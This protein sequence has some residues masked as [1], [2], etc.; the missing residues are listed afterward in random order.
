MM[1]QLL[2]FFDVYINVNI[3]I[4][5]YLTFGRTY[6]IVADTD[7]ARGMSWTPLKTAVLRPYREKCGERAERPLTYSR[8]V[9]VE[10][11]R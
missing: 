8:M 5:Y 11:I 7:S 9:R 6:N 10:K 3:F 2:Q 1:F 4:V